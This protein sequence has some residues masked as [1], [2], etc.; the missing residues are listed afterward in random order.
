MTKAKLS[1]FIDVGSRFSVSK[2]PFG[3]VPDVSKTILWIDVEAYKQDLLSTKTLRRYH[4]ENDEVVLQW[5]LAVIQPEK[6]LYVN[7]AFDL[8][9][10]V[11]NKDIVHPNGRFR[12]NDIVEMVRRKCC[13]RSLKELIPKLKYMALMKANK[14]T[15]K[16]LWG[17]YRSD[18]KEYGTY[19]D[20]FFVGGYTPEGELITRFIREEEEH[21]VQK[22]EKVN[23]EL[24]LEYKKKYTQKQLYEFAQ[25]CEIKC[26]KSSTKEMLC[27]SLAEKVGNKYVM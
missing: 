10:C 21:L 12:G 4:D 18:L 3:F 23:D 5:M 7:I 14:Y 13:K 19:P 1:P 26:T 22:D 8:T 20:F 2:N 11:V 25:E 24:W 27:K 15:P 16:T 9:F 6:D 17:K